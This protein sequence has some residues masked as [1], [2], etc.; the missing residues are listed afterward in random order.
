[1]NRPCYVT[2]LLGLL[3]LAA[4]STAQ[5]APQ[6][7]IDYASFAYDE[8]ESLVELYMAF[9]ASTLTY[10]AR[11]SLYTSSIPIQLNL[12]SSSDTDLDASAERVVWEQEMDLQFAV[13]DTS[14]ITE[15]QVFLRQIRLT[16]VPGEY[17]LQI[18]MPLSGQDPAQAGRDIIIPDYSQ[19]ESCT[20]SDITLASMITLS[21]DREDPFYKNG[22]QIRP[23]ASQLYGEGVANL[24]YYAE[25]YNTACAASDTG[26]Y[27]MLIYVSEE[28]ID[29]PVPVAGLEKRSKRAMHSMDVL[30][31]RF[32]LSSLV[33][34]VYFLHMEILD[35]AN[36]SKFA[37]TRKFFVSNPVMDLTWAESSIFYVNNY[38]TMQED[39]A[40]RALIRIRHVEDVTAFIDIDEQPELIGGIIKL[41]SKVKYPQSARRARIQGRVIV[42]FTVD[43]EGY[44]RDFM[45]LRGIGGGCDEEVIRVITEHARFK[46][47]ISHGKAVP[48][49]A[50]LPVVQRQNFLVPTTKLFTVDAVI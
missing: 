19:Q 36:E 46:P 23:N 29:G 12:L 49:R 32:D 9:K 20:L 42:Q 25:A 17:E 34:G 22:L 13:M 11:D 3:L 6:I 24:F 31:G 43:K 38:T 14:V 47:A 26:E 48:V 21:E 27:T 35:K 50:S 44:P 30:V 16:V 39:V 4:S 41:Q 5:Q 37:Q 7:D 2:I 1:M 8:Q 40:E 28:S 45:V 15:G 18:V 10:E 33:S